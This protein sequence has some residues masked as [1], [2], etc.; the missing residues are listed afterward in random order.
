MLLQMGWA[1]SVW[2]PA[3][4]REGRGMMCVSAHVRCIDGLF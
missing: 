1:G 2:F 3:K 4:K